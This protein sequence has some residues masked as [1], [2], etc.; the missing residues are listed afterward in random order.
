MKEGGQGGGRGRRE[1][2]GRMGRG[3]GRRDGEGEEGREGE[4]RGGGGG[5]E[6]G[7]E[8]VRGGGGRGPLSDLPIWQP[9]VVEKKVYRKF[10]L[11]TRTN[12][13]L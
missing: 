1:R 12:A 11:C 6:V 3:G 7:E 5:E 8:E 4:G 9:R 10:E 13:E 2:E